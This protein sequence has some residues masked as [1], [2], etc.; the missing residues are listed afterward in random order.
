MGKK[1]KLIAKLK[2]KPKDFTW[3]ELM[4]LL[5][6]IGYKEIKGGKTSG[7]RV[8]FLGENGS[9]IHLHKPHPSNSLKRYQMKLIINKLEEE[10]LI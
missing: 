4:V 1:E 10:G 3:S 6:Q 2:S 7:S 5:N 9:M 8:K